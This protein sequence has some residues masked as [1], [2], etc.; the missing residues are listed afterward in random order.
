MK[1]IKKS[2]LKDEE[3]QKKLLKAIESG[4]D[5]DYDGNENKVETFD[6]YFALRRVLELLKE[7]SND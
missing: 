6:E 4:K 7:Y 3:F 5:Y 1:A 2:L